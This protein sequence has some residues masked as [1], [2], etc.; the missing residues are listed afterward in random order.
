M[1]FLLKLEGKVSGQRYGKTLRSEP[2]HRKLL[3]RRKVLGPM[4]VSKL[5]E[6]L[7]EKEMEALPTK[8]KKKKEKVSED[9]EEKEG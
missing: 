6:L 3:L 4:Q 2:N 7:I 8:K 1:N 5:L 9:A